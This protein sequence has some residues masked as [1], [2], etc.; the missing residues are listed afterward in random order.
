MRTKAFNS[1]VYNLFRRV[2]GGNVKENVQIKNSRIFV[3]WTEQI[4]KRSKLHQNESAAVFYNQ[5]LKI[6]KMDS[7]FFVAQSVQ[8]IIFHGKN[9]FSEMNRQISKPKLKIIFS[10]IRHWELSIFR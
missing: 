3:A 5:K 2:L 8:F 9:I 7:F 1:S 4:T 10:R 6:Y